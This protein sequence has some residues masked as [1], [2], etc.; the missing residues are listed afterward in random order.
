MRQK[1]FSPRIIEICKVCFANTYILLTMYPCNYFY[2]SWRIRFLIL[3]ISKYNRNC[4][5][6][7]YRLP[8][9]HSRLP[10]GH[11]IYDSKSFFIQIRIN[12]TYYFR[13]R[14]TAIFVNYK[15]YNNTTLNFTFYRLCRILDIATQKL[16]S[17]FCPPGKSGIVSTT[18]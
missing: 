8:F 10:L 3:L 6:H 1:F 4:I 12:T 15:L 17:S 14:N 16:S 9:L 13:I 18:E 2:K 5:L 11:R 7:R